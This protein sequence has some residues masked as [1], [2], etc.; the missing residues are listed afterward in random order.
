VLSELDEKMTIA[1]KTPAAQQALWFTVYD[2]DYP[3]RTLDPTQPRWEPR[4][5]KTSGWDASTRNVRFE[6]RGFDADY[7]ELERKQ[8]QSSCAYNIHGGRTKPV[9]DVRVRFVLTPGSRDGT[10]HVRLEKSQR[11]FW[12]T[13]HMDGLVTL[14]ASAPIPGASRRVMVSKEL[15]PFVPGKSVKVSFETVDYRLALKI[16]GKEAVASSDDPDSPAYYGPNLKLLR[17]AKRRPSPH[18][19]IYGETG[20]FDLAHLVVER[21]MYYYHDPTFRA[22]ALSWA[23]L[24]GWG[25]VESPI[26]LWEHEYFMLGDNTSSSKDSR[27]WDQGADHLQA[28][29]E[30]FQLGTVPRDQLIGKAF[31]VY[32]PS[33]HR[34]GWLP[35]LGDWAWRIIPD[36]GRMRW[37]R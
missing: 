4:Y 29:G 1:R 6:S 24:S 22:L 14:S 31:F 27:L 33:G 28:R 8:I 17:R 15:T 25:S 5:R 36:V 34:I 9:S 20:S 37:I 32:W 21:D 35:R 7:I 23:P 30:A 19:R 16:G 11:A 13:I 2:H 10:L 3:P 18:P 26:L 12:A